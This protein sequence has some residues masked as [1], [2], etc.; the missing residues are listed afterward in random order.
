MNLPPA[1][2]T[3]RGEDT[4]TRYPALAAW[5]LRWRNDPASREAPDLLWRLACLEAQAQE[6]DAGGF[7]D[8]A[9]VVL[10]KARC[11]AAEAAA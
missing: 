1:S 6:L 3:E 4:A 9:D 8:A 10:L 5:Q 7:H 2:A 11:L